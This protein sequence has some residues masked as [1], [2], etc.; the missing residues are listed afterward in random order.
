MGMESIG[1]MP[2]DIDANPLHQQFNLE[3]WHICKHPLPLNRER[4]TLPP[5]DS[6]LHGACYRQWHLLEDTPCMG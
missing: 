5:T 6:I 2:T 1:Q 3:S 4:G